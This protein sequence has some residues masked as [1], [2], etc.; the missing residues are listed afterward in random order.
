MKPISSL[1][2]TTYNKTLFIISN[3]S[4]EDKNVSE[5][6]KEDIVNRMSKYL[7]NAGQD[8]EMNPFILVKKL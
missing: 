2:S 5:T 3:F 8:K 6:A 4:S 7:E 1:S